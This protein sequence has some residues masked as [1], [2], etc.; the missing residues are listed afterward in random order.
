MKLWPNPIPSQNPWDR[1]F[2]VTP[3]YRV[4]TGPG[5]GRSITSNM[6]LC[7]YIGFLPHEAPCYIWLLLRNYIFWHIFSIYHTIT[8]SHNHI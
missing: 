4:G 2:P 1:L 3:T 7:A 6:K 8:H 5:A